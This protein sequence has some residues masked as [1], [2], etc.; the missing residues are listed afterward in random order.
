[1]NVDVVLGSWKTT[2]RELK[3]LRPGDHIVLPD[4]EDGWLAADNVRLRLA[5]IQFAERKT[6][7]EIK[8]SARLR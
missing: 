5:R 2:I 8:R 7:V 1:M 4:G 3:R 6:S